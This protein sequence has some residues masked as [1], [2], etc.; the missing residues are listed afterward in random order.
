[1]RQAVVVS[2]TP[3]ASAVSGRGVR[4]VSG[5]HQYIAVTAAAAFVCGAGPADA[6]VMDRSTYAQS[7]AVS[8]AATG[9][10]W[11]RFRLLAE[12]WRE[13]RGIT[14]SVTKMVLCPSYQ[15]IISM[16]DRAVPLILRSMTDEGNDPD[17]WFW[18]LE[19]ITGEDPI[20]VQAY[21][22]TRRMAQAWL[23]WAK[24]KYAW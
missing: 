24:G 14:S 17:H 13:E 7:G 18:A 9:E 16:G 2:G 23:D 12:R 15:R 5:F 8:L 19:M 22:N 1:M 3:R 10:D 21:G 11:Q 4:R 6:M 20:P